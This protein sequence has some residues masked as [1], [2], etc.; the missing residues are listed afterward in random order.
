ME[1]YGYNDRVNGFYPVLGGGN[2]VGFGNPTGLTQKINEIYFSTI[3]RGVY[4]FTPTQLA[5]IFSIANQCPLAGGVS[6]YKARSLYAIVNDEA[7]YD[8]TGVCNALG[9][10]MRKPQTDEVISK[11]VPV[12]YP[13]PANRELS[14]YCPDI[15][16]KEA[17]LSVYDLTGKRLMSV[18]LTQSNQKIALD[19]ITKGIYLVQIISQGNLL[20]NEKLIVE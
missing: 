19:R 3:A 13:N 14:V 12:I 7:E 20:L 8:D 11:K 5:D 1:K 15:E 9:M 2:P 18:P 4:T 17:L 10:S 16:Q 6:V